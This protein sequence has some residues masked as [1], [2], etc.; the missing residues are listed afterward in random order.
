MPSEVWDCQGH[1]RVLIIPIKSKAGPKSAHVDGSYFLPAIVPIA[2]RFAV[3]ARQHTTPGPDHCDGKIE[4]TWE[5]VLEALSDPAVAELA[6][7]PA[8]K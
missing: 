8:V 5:L 7:L 1:S 6:A 2:S 4:A 3:R